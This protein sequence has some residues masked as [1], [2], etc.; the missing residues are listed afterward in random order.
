VLD[1]S[2]SL[3]GGVISATAGGGGVDFFRERGARLGRA[4]G[5]SDV[6]SV[7]ATAT[8]GGVFDREARFFFGGGS[9]AGWA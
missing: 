3:G 8:G 9:D 5:I 6:P 4:G 2:A 7:G 1:T